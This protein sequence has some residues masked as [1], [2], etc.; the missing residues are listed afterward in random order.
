M[1]GYLSPR[2]FTAKFK[3]SRLLKIEKDR[4]INEMIFALYLAIFPLVG[5]ISAVK[6]G[7]SFVALLILSSSLIACS[8]Y[9]NFIRTSSY[10]SKQFIAVSLIVLLVLSFDIAF[11]YNFYATKYAY[12]FIFFGLLPAFLLS[13]IENTVNLIKYLSIFSVIVISAY[14]L[15]PLNNYFFSTDYLKYGYSIMLPAFMAAHLG[16]K[17]MHYRWLLIFEFIS[18]FQLLFFGNKGAFAVALAYV[19]LN[20][21]FIDGL[22]RRKILGI[23][24]ACITAIVISATYKPVLVSVNDFLISNNINSYS[25]R[26]LEQGALEG[27]DIYSGR[28][29]IWSSAIVQSNRSPI[30]GNGSGYFISQ[31]GVYTH[32][33]FLELVTSWGMVGLVVF[34][35]VFGS[36]IRVFRASVRDNKIILLFFA[37]LGVA[38]LLFSLEIFSWVYFW[39]FIYSIQYYRVRLK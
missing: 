12:Q 22:N 9:I 33:I 30:V 35:I 15:D 29:S 39:I 18:I 20:K 27:G 6:P 14:T 8:I 26:S 10:V 38:P 21:L 1:I 34:L 28:E 16:R 24:V 31:R 7:T 37:T 5:T 2:L 32:N 17:Y 4:S 23:F 19:I 3:S 11:R 25:L 36:F 13:R